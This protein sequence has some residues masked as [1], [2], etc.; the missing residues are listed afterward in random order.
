MSKRVIFSLYIDIPT[1]EIDY[2]PPHYGDTECK[3]VKAKREFM[4]YYEWLKSTQVKYAESC[5]VDYKFFEYDDDYIAYDKMFKE[6]Y[7][8][9]TKYNIINFYKLELMY[10]LAEEYDE[11]L[12]L[13]LDVVP[14]TKENF[15]DVWDLSKGLVIRLN[16]LP[17]MYDTMIG[18]SRLQKKFNRTLANQ[19]NRSPFAKFWNARA[20]LFEEGMSC[21][22]GG[23]FNTGIVGITKDQLAEMAY[24]E[25]FADTLALMDDLINDEDSHWPELM[26]RVFGWDNET[27]WAYKT[28]INEVEFQRMDDKWHFTLDK[29]SDVFSTAKLVHVIN[30]NFKAVKEQYE[31][32]NL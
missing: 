29:R 4:E 18:I 12:Y 17:P 14:F 15:F 5:G 2:Q 24:F 7:P 21:D 16:D 23:T 11:I 28:A 10:R 30:K 26:T 6:K 1:E 20:M 25:D 27:I 22:F 8:Q 19:S 32:R 9:I 3:N 13:D 31:A